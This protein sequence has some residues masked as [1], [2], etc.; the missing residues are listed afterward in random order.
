MILKRQEKNNVIEAMYDSSNIIAST[1]NKE[2][3]DLVLTFNKGNKYKYPKV[4][5]SD[6]TRFE[7]AES[8]GKVFNTHIKNYTFEKMDGVNPDTIIK[9]IDEMREAEE[10]AILIS[11]SSSL[12]N[13]MKSVIAGCEL[14]G[15][16]VNSQLE[17]LKGFIDT[18]ISENTK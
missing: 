16:F 9:E 12:K 10:K 6:Y 1:Y 4:S 11:K 13:K 17:E 14:S 2:T 3:Q 8:Q 7:I 15:F 5:S 18:F